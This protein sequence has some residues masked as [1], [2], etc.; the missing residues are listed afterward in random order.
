CRALA[1]KVG[2]KVT[3][4]TKDG[5][6]KGRLE[7][8][9]PDKIVLAE[10]IIVAGRDSGHTKR[11][12]AWSSLTVEEDQGLAA[13]WAPE[14]ADDW[15]AFALVDLCHGDA[16]SARSVLDVTGR[17]P[18]A[19]WLREKIRALKPKQ[20]GSSPTA[21]GGKE[22]GTEKKQAPAPT[23]RAAWITGDIGKVRVAGSMEREGGRYVLKGAGSDIWQKADAFFFAYQRAHGD[24]EITARVVSMTN[25][26]QH[27]KAGIMIR[28][29]ATPD[30]AAV[31][32]NL[33]P[34]GRKEPSRRLTAGGSFDIAG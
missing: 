17:H 21:S 3:L 12:I 20:A 5:R 13:A 16:D 26:S 1:G 19:G 24:C 14:N 29:G 22:A 18:L 23:P 27:A 7:Q 30:A 2:E 8:V 10:K 28:A 34:G 33:L 15:M 9:T 25:T 32:L 4:D 11:N 31:K 6:R